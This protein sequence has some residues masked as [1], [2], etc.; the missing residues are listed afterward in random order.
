MHGSAVTIT[1]VSTYANPP[2]LLY[3][4][5]RKLHTIGAHAADGRRCIAAASKTRRL[6]HGEPY[7]LHAPLFPILIGIFKFSCSILRKE[8]CNIVLTCFISRQVSNSVRRTLRVTVSDRAQLLSRAQETGYLLSYGATYSLQGDC[9]LRHHRGATAQASGP[10]SHQI[11]RPLAS[12][13]VS[14]RRNFMRVG[15]AQQ[16]LTK[17]G[18]VGFIVR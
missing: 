4:P 3:E 11:H 17:P 16:T 13:L 7:L 9:H 12:S 8:S 1:N 5:W 10:L 2:S 18:L 15:R 14:C 6:Q